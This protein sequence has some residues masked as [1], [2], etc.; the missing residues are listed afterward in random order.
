MSDIIRWQELP[1]NAEDKSVWLGPVITGYYVNM[2]TDVGQNGS[3]LYELML[4]D[5]GPNYKRKVSI[6]GSDLLD[7]RFALIPKNCMVRVTCLGIQQPKRQGGRAY[8]G[9][10]V[11]FDKEA[12]K[13]ADFV[14]VATDP[15]NS[16]TAPQ[17]TAPSNAA[18]VGAGYTGPVGTTTP[19]AAPTQPPAGAGF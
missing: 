16:V 7:E 18:V 9:F 19:P 11:E 13:P 8:M 10:K 6:W 17:T 4:S 2:K 5:P 1:K 15:T 14:E 12:M 3:N